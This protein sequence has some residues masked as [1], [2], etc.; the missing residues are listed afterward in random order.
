MVKRGTGRTGFLL[1]EV[2]VALAIFGLCASMLVS[3]AFNVMRFL[4]DFEDTRERDQDL[5]FVR[6]EV[7]SLADHEDLEEGG[8]IQTLSLGL[9][10]WEL[11]DLETTE[12]L[13]VYL[14]TL[15]FEWDGSD[16]VDAGE[17]ETSAYVLRPTWSNTDAS[18][19]SARE[20]LYTDKQRKIEEIVRDHNWR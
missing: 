3:G 16:E 12:L 10:E 17:R 14:V 20:Q 1:I 6:S 8:E 11:E 4:R 2:L 18:L 19:K 13:D 5:Q 9:V 7:L 15:Y